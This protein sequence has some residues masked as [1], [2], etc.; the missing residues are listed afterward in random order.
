MT[1]MT[2]DEFHLKA[3]EFGAGLIEQVAEDPV[4]RIGILNAAAQLIAAFAIE[5]QD[6]FRT[7][8]ELSGDIHSE[9]M[10]MTELIL[11]G[12]VLASETGNVIPMEKLQ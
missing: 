8:E 9:A 12:K 1:D 7:I 3:R 5:A 11:T 2:D 4:G 10:A 6:P